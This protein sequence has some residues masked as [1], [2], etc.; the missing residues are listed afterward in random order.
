MTIR[1]DSSQTIYDISLI[2]YGDVSMVYKLIEENPS[3]ISLLSDLTGLTLNYTPNTIN[4]TSKEATIITFETQ[5]NVTIQSTQ[6]LFDVSL[7][8]YGTAEKVYQLIDENPTIIG[9]LDS[10]YTGKKLNYIENKT[11]IPTYFRNNEIVVSTR[12]ELTATSSSYDFY[13]LKEDGFY[14][15]K[16]DGFKIII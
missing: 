16:E 10:N 9:I 15:L 4:Y 12:K 13:L 8:Y 5:K 14:L 6:T 7:Q 11:K 2:A 1:V 3:I